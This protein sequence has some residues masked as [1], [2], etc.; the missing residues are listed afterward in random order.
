MAS[1]VNKGKYKKDL[2]GLKFGRATVLEFSHM[3]GV[4]NHVSFWRC[5]CECG[6]EFVTRGI[7]LS[8]GTT[9]SC[10]CYVREVNSKRGKDTFTNNLKGYIEKKR[11]PAGESSR[12][13]LFYL[14]KYKAEKRGIEFALSIDEFSTLNKMNCRYCG[15]E[16]SQIKLQK[17]V[18]PYIYNGIDRI[19]SKQG[20]ISGN[21]APCCGT[22][23]TAKLA[24]TEDQFAEWAT[25]VYNNFAA[26]K[27]F[28]N[29]V[30]V[31]FQP[32]G[33]SK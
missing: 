29:S 33:I 7:H 14:Y 20:Y 2:K 10:G 6:K 25:R 1:R 12:N 8:S 19:D 9:R 5:L 24:M 28:W 15:A 4:E 11:K 16:P 3:G 13:H 30:Y 23:N 31:D 21:V 22:C 17:G 32:E 27:V 18:N 26:N